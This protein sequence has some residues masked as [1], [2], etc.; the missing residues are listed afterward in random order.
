[1]TKLLT[2]YRCKS[3]PCRCKD[4]ITIYHTDCRDILRLLE[5]GSVDV[6]LTD[7]PYGIVVQFGE[8]RGQGGWGPSTRR[9]QFDWDT[10]VIVDEV[11]SGLTSAFN[12]CKPK[13]SC[14]VWTGFDSAERYAEPARRAG[15]TVKPAA[16]VKEHHPPAGKGNWWPSGFELAYYGYRPGA[17]FADTNRHRCNVWFADSYRFGKRN[18]NGH[19]TQKPLGMTREH[20]AAIVPPR[21]LVLDPF[22]GS[23]T[24][25]RAAKDLGRRAIGVEID[26]KYC[27]IAAERLRQVVCLPHD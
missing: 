12:L 3:Q 16:W 21:G 24:T 9:M 18:K 20:V 1:M 5:P 10:Q 2:C 4:G 25:L 6:V 14:F 8:N 11:R 17:W 19:P 13:A 7:P 15:F 22:M 26:E 27:E 23:G